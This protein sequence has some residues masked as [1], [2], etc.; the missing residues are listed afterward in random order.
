MWMLSRD[1][2]AR[3]RGDSARPAHPL[4]LSEDLVDEPEHGEDEREAADDRRHDAGREA[5]AHRLREHDEEDADDED[6]E[7]IRHA[8]MRRGRSRSGAA[9]AL[10]AREPPPRAG[11]SSSSGWRSRTG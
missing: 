6:V 10:L 9:A 4:R 11:R 3:L 7:Q 1:L 5:P 2:L 8:D